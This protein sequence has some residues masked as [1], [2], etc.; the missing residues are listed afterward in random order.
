MKITTISTNPAILDVEFN[1]LN[2]IDFLPTFESGTY[3]IN[4]G[5]LIVSSERI[6]L[7]KDPYFSEIEN[8]ILKNCVIEIL[9]RLLDIEFLRF[10]FFEG[11]FS[12]KETLIKHIR[13][14]KK[15]CKPGFNMSWHLDNRWSIM[16]GIINV[17]DNK[18]STHFSKKELL[19]L[20]NGKI[21]DKKDVFHV[22]NIKKFTG[23]F[24]A[25]TE[26]TWHCVPYCHE[27]RRIILVDC[28]I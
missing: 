18:V 19:W 17:Q 10:P 14:S 11:N 21:M 3:G 9:Y 20:D 15:L 24:W 4:Y 23:T 16:A 13:L 25:N 7:V 26:L 27:D 1:E 5:N 22:A 6:N 2:N 28:V 12:K 8:S